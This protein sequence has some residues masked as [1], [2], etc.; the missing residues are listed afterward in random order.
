MS[1]RNRNRVRNVRYAAR[2]PAQVLQCSPAVMSMRNRARDHLSKARDHISDVPVHARIAANRIHV[3]ASNAWHRAAGHRIQG[4]RG[5]LANAR[6]VRAQ[7][8]GRRDLPRRAADNLRSSLPIVRDRIDTSTGRPNRDSRQ[9]GRTID[10]SLARMAPQRRRDARAS[11][12][13][14]RRLGRTQGRVR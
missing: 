3:R 10:E 1:M 11:L 12:D 13:E 5:R 8:R 7:Q 2:H 4:A 6:A 9:I 14:A